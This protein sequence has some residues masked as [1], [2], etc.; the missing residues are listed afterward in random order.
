M[1]ETMEQVAEKIE[2]ASTVSLKK[3]A[4][5]ITNRRNALCGRY[6]TTSFSSSGCS[7]YTWC[8]SSDDSRYSK[9]LWG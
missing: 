8:S 1:T 3:Q 5:T 4:D 2:A 6:W 9:C 7:S